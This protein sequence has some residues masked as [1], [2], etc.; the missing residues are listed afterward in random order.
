LVAKRVGFG[1]DVLDLL[2]RLLSPNYIH[3]V[4]ELPSKFFHVFAPQG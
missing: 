3:F 4:N 2:R 1:A